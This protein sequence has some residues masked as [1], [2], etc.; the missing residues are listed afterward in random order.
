MSAVEI[1]PVSGIAVEPWLDELAAL[2]IRVFRDFP[3]LYEGSMDY[4]RRYLDGYAR[5]DKSVFVL[6]M[7]YNRLVGAATALPLTDAAPDFQAPFH[8]HGP[9]AER[10]FYFG[11]S[12]L[13]SDYRGQG[14]GHRFFDLRELYAHDFGYAITAFC[15][16]IR[17]PAHP[18]RPAGNRS[19]EPFWEKRGYR[20]Q[21]E[22]EARFSW[23]DLGDRAPSEKRLRFWLRDDSDVKET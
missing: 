5:S 14:I 16:V 6:A 13:L 12:V 1:R 8:R 23:T 18:L 17:D 21:A 9:D 3:Y 10:V 11:E 7:E 15:A 22:L 4:E 2:R 20:P 19:L